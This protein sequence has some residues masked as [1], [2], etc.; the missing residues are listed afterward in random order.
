VGRRQLRAAVKRTGAEAAGGEGDK[1]GRVLCSER[2][3]GG[4]PVGRQP[5]RLID[6]DVRQTVRGKDPVHH[7]AA[8]A[9]VEYVAFKEE[10][11]H[12]RAPSR[13]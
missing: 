8:A 12:T 2:R 5:G 4:G 7:G 10:E 3:T 6:D 9:R 11:G 1:T 13:S